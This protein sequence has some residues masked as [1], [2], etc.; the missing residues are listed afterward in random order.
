MKRI[1]SNLAC[2]LWAMGSTFFLAS[3][4]GASPLVAIASALSFLAGSITCLV[5]NNVK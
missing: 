3:T 2:V 1:L 4:V 5:A